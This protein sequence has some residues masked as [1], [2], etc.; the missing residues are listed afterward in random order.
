MVHVERLEAQL[1]GG[2]KLLARD[3]AAQIG[4]CGGDR[5]RQV[6]QAVP[7]TALGRV[8]VAASASA[9]AAMTSTAAPMTAASAMT[10]APTVRRR[11]GPVRHGGA[12]VGRKV[13][14]RDHFLV[15]RDFV[16]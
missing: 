11:I 9:P 10:R 4:I 8:S 5:F 7:G 14:G 12:I 15:I 3:S 16:R 2:A 1:R 6:K 13:L